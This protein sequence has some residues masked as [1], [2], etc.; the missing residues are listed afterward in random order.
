MLARSR[1]VFT[2]S[3]KKMSESVFLIAEAG[4]NHNGNI[5]LALDMID[6]AADAGADAVKFQTF[7]ATELVTRSAQKAR[8]Q[9]DRT[10][11]AGGQLEMLRQLELSEEEHVKLVARCAD[12]GITFM[13][14]AFDTASL[15]MLV[16]LG[17]NVTKVPSGDITCA[18]L[19]LQ[20]ARLR[21]RLIVSTGMCN[22]TD[23]EQALGVIAFGLTHDGYPQNRTDCEAAYFS[24]EGQKALKEHVT[25]LHCVTQYPAPVEAINLRAMDTMAAAFGLPVGYSDHSVGIEIAIAAV[26]R[27]ACV[28]EKHF[29]LNRTLPGPDH[30]ASLQPD[31]FAEMTRSIRAV[32]LALGIALKHPATTELENRVAARRSVV[33]KRAIEPGERLSLEVLAWKRPG[34]G[35]SP[36][37]IWGLQDKN[38]TR[39]YQPDEPISP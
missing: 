25:L 1:S 18:P 13:S 3:I 34:N 17:V 8:Y 39:G 38:A 28:I 36:M 15:D 9:I 20:V 6:A 12:R 10:G 30:A 2:Y 35:I 21:Q 32:Q 24:D 4:V 37:D 5:A 27:G 7:R 33:A 23:I 22:M 16:R 19:L 11:D 31:E 26:A 29:T 14:T